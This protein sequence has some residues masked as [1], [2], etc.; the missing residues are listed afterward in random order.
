[1]KKLFW[2]ILV[3]VIAAVGRW[4]Q[5]FVIYDCWYDGEEKSCAFLEVAR[6]D[7]EHKYGLMNRTRLP[8]YRWMV[9]VRETESVRSFWMKNTKIPLHIIFLDS[10]KRVVDQTTMTPCVADPCPSYTS[11]TPA[12]YVVEL[13]AKP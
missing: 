2:V 13:W 8:P 6:T 12:Q 4:F 3:M 10:E 1:M 5:D 7:E 11:R 9:F